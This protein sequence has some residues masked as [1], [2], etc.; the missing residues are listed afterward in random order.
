MILRTWSIIDLNFFYLVAASC[1]VKTLSLLTVASA[2]FKISLPEYYENWLSSRRKTGG[3]KRWVI[4][5]KQYAIV[6]IVLSFVLEV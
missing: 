6:S 1:S 5:F 3:Q 2:R 4:V